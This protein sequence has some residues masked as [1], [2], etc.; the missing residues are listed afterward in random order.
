M[1]NRKCLCAAE[2]H[3]LVI[4]SCVKLVVA[5]SPFLLLPSPVGDQGE[6]RFGLSTTND[7]ATSYQQALYV[8]TILTSSITVAFFINAAALSNRT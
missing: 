3:A 2:T 8:D 6:R 7:N 4:P 5:Q 1:D